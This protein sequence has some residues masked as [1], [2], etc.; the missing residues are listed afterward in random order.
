MK[1]PHRQPGFL[2]GTYIV[3]KQSKIVQ[4]TF[5]FGN[6]EELPFTLLILFRKFITLLLISHISFRIWYGFTIGEIYRLLLVSRI[7]THPPQTFMLEY[8]VSHTWCIGVV[9]NL[10]LTFGA[11][12]V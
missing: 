4:N 3:D 8:R 9:Y 10:R 12:L 6:R 5:S 7:S 1:S 2:C 11:E